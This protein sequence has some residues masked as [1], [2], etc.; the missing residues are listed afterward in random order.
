MIETIAPAAPEQSNVPA[1]RKMDIVTRAA[2]QMFLD[3]G[4]SATS[5]DAIAKAAGVS[6]ATLYAYFPSKEALFASLIVAECESLQRDLP[7]PQLSAGLSEALR[8]FA[9]QYLSAFI[10]GK[11]FAFV[12]IIANESGRFPVLARLFYESG[13]QAT[14]RRL[15]GFLEEARAKKLLEFDDPMEAATQFLSLIRGELPLMIVLGLSELTEKAVEEGIEAGLK[16][17][18]KACQARV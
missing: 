8:T 9:R 1:G 11:D 15:S 3:Q 10:H 16:F 18:L 14:I 17:F 6:K 12:R 4:F 2:W 5:M 13:P 7:L